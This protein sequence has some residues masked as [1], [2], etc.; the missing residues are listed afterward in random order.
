MLLMARPEVSQQ[1]HV[2]R[3]HGWSRPPRWRRWIVQRRR[4]RRSP[5]G[6]KIALTAEKLSGFRMRPAHD[7]Y[8]RPA[9]RP[10]GVSLAPLTAGRRSDFIPCTLLNAET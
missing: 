5:V 8:L 1:V 9:I 4:G 7:P 3:R 6:F 2:T 10:W